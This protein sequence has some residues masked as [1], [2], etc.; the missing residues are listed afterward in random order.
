MLIPCN[1]Y[2]EMLYRL[3]WDTW[4]WEGSL[5]YTWFQ[6]LFFTC[7]WHCRQM[8]GIVGII[9]AGANYRFYHGKYTLSTMIFIIPITQE[10]LFR[11]LVGGTVWWGPTSN[12]RSLWQRQ[13]LNDYSNSQSFLFF[14]RFLL[15]LLLSSFFIFF[16]FCAYVHEVVVFLGFFLICLSDCCCYSWLW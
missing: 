3:D 2:L 8:K 16:T 13:K 10:T 6:S 15:N 12:T 14:C 9:G 7:L 4:F 5:E 11:C 1:I